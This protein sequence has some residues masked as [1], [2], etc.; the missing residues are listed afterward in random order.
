M[1]RFN[2]D[3][4]EYDDISETIAQRFHNYIN[5]TKEFMKEGYTSHGRSFHATFAVSHGKVLSIGFNNYRRK[6][7]YIKGL[8]NLKHFDDPISE[9]N[10]SLHSEIH[11]LLKLGDI[12]YSSVQMFNVHISRN[13]KCSM[14]KPCPNCIETLRRVGVRKIFYYDD[15]KNGFKYIKL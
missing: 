13:G 6:V 12:D 5:I 14:S 15:K 10:M 9:Y 1:I 7:N 8:G 11:T 3:I 4:K 2:L